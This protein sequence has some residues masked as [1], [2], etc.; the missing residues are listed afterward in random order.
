[1]DKLCSNCSKDE[2]G[3]L[4]DTLGPAD[5][6]KTKPVAATTTDT[7]RLKTATAVPAAA[8]PRGRV[9]RPFPSGINPCEET[10]M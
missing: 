7:T 3:E 2:E 4:E 10:S 6:I 5:V 8:L 1:V 9:P